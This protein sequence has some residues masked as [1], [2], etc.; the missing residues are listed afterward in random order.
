MMINVLLF[1]LLIVSQNEVPYKPQEEFDLK[2]HYDFRPKDEVVKG[3]TDFTMMGMNDQKNAP[4][5]FI[6][7]TVKWIKLPNNETKLKVIDNKGTVTGK[8]IKEGAMYTL[9]IG[10]AE[11]VKSGAKANEYNLVLMDSDKKE[12][13]R[14][15][16]VLKNNGGIIVNGE[17][18]M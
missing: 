16:L 12:I 18:K 1:L 14:I 3:P 13:N 5:S 11:D 8:K 2:L 15:H 10:F 7:L 6:T 4:L 17:E 9:P